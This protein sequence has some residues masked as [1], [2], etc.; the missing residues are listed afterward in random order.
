MTLLNY[1]FSEEAI[2]D[3]EL[4]WEYTKHEW[5]QEQAN[6]YYKNLEE[7]IHFLRSNHL[8]GKSQ[9]QIIPGL[10]N[11]LV[12]SHMIYYIIDKQNRLV[13]ARILHKN[14]NAFKQFR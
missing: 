14:M 8:A 11:Y 7:G 3:L 5:S 6:S 2:N 9:D 4:I 1:R 12:Q 10:R 13:I